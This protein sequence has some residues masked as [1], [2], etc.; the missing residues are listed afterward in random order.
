M[1]KN[2]F[3]IVLLLGGILISSIAFTQSD[4]AFSYVE[5]YNQKLDSIKN[6]QAVFTVK[7]D[8]P[9]LKIPVSS[10]KMFFKWPAHYSI[11]TYQFTVMPKRKLTPVTRFLRRSDF[12][13]LDRGIEMVNKHKCKVVEL[14]PYD[15]T[16]VVSQYTIWVD[17]ATYM[18]R[19]VFVL[20][21]DGSEYFYHYT[22]QNGSDLLPSKLFY[23]F[24][25]VLPHVQNVLLNPVALNNDVESSKVFE[26]KI[27]INFE[28]SNIR[29]FH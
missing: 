27:T 23:T 25:Y 4:D 3:N 11:S 19:R 17:I 14:Y 10:G 21:N 9:L 6:Y 8:I 24:N 1:K 12:K 7:S 16:S 2:L 22:Y 13:V 29:K 20:E 26:G 5:R 15:T 28:Y 18:V